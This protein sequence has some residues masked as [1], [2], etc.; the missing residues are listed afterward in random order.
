MDGR[1]TTLFRHP[2]ATKAPAGHA[3]ALLQSGY[4]DFL[5]KIHV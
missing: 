2:L 1:T 3:T 5:Q 4:M